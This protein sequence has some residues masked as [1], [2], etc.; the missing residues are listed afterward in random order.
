MLFRSS[1]VPLV[2][3]RLV[4]LVDVVDLAAFLWEPDDVVASWYAADQLYPKGKGAA[5]AMAA[6]ERARLTLAEVDVADF[7]AEELEARSR[8]AAEEMGWKAG[9]FFRPLRLAITGRAVSP[10]LFGSI[11]L[12][13]RERTLARIDDALA[14]LADFARAGAAAR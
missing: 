7:A 2:R 14:K 13:G 11:E 10:P 12:L 8:A 4:R 6:L 9:D 3:E 5:E 1:M